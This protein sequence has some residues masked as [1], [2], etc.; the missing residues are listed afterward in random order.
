MPG[1]AP[2]SLRGLVGAAGGSLRPP[3]SGS[4]RW[5]RRI[6][7][8]GAFVVLA[9][10]VPAFNTRGLGAPDSESVSLAPALSVP[11]SAPAG[12][13]APTIGTANTAVLPDGRFATPAGRSIVTD[14]YSNNVIV[15]RAGGR[16]YT[17]SEAVSND[18][19]L[20][21]NTRVYSVI[22]AATLSRRRVR[23]D[24]MQY[25]LAESPDGTTLYVSEAG[26]DSIGIFYTSAFPPLWP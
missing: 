21:N 26:K 17:S 14:A 11:L 25:G 12:S 24:D 4:G 5:A 20:P 7:R 8:L 22:D 23:D 9:V 19:Q 13:I 3:G 10:M 16:V 1:V 2:T 18:P 6:L 15:S